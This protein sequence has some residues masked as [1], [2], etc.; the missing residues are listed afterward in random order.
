MVNTELNA[1]K[2]NAKTLMY[3][4]IYTQILDKEKTI[5][6]SERSLFQLSEILRRGSE[7]Q[8]LSFESNKKTHATMQKFIPLYLEHFYFLIKRAGWRATKIYSYYMFEQERFK[9]GFIIM[10]QKSRQKA[11]INVEKD[12]FKLLNTYFRY[13]CRNN[14]DNCI[15]EPICDELDEITYLKKYNSLFDRSLSSFV[16]LKLIGDKVE[17][18]YNEKTLKIKANDFKATRIN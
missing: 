6:P 12:F 7:N 14:L 18:D 4:E 16:N 17:R 2:A 10:N 13:D 5:D 9:K 1:A 8:L 11:E 15:F 3:N